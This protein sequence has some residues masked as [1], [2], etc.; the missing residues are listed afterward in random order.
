MTNY[1]SPL[2]VDSTREMIKKHLNR[3]QELY[4]VGGFS[5]AIGLVVGKGLRKTPKIDEAALVYKWMEE[6]VSNGF[7]VYALSN[8]Q[9]GLWEACWN[10]V[11][12][13]SSRVNLPIPNVVDILTRE[14][15]E[16]RVHL[17]L[18]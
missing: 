17:M 9:K 15:D 8:E 4:I 2:N 12:S 7:S 5:L 14:F 1:T 18:A 3:N 16:S 10:W 11:T 13:E 6:Q